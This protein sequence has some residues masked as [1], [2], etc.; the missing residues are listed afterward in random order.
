[1]TRPGGAAG[2]QPFLNAEDRQGRTLAGLGAGAAAA[3]I[4]AAPYLGPALRVAGPPLVKYGL[5][6]A[7]VG[8]GAEATAEFL[9]LMRKLWGR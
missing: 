2:V 4:G 1:M 7:G 6:G 5:K 3:G 9:N 8:A